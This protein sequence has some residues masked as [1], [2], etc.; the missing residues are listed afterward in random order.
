MFTGSLISEEPTTILP[1]PLIALASLLMFEVEE[2]P[3]RV[4]S[5]SGLDAHGLDALQPA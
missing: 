3:P 5:S 4:P 1:L 2:V